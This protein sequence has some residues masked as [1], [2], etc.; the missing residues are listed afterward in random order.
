MF[1]NISPSMFW[2]II[3]IFLLMLELL[4]PMPTLLIAGAFGLGALVV[5]G[6]LAIA[7]AYFVHA[8]IQMLIWVLASGFLVWYSRRFVPKGSG[9][10]SDAVE[11]VALTPIPAGQTGRV[12]Y[13]GNSWKARCDDPKI[14]IAAEEKVYVLRKQGTTLIVMPENWLYETK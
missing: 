14:A 7:Q 11:G 3:G 4:V 6:F 8:A 9:R 1:T 2:L 10:I 12:K 13:E 5:A